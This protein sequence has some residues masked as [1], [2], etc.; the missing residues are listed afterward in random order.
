ML[1][2]GKENPAW[3]KLSNIWCICIDKLNPY[4]ADMKEKCETFRD[5]N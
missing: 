5:K 1:I 4:K 2:Q 3:L